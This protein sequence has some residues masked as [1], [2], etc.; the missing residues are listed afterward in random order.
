MQVSKELL[1][2]VLG[3]KDIKVGTGNRDLLS[4]WP[5]GKYY[6]TMNVY[7]FAHK[8]KKWAL[9]NGAM[10]WEIKE[11]SCEDDDIYTLTVQ[12]KDGTKGV[13]SPIRPED[14]NH[15]EI[16]ATEWVL[17]QKGQTM[18]IVTVWKRTF[19]DMENV[20]INA[21]RDE[22]LGNFMAG[23]NKTAFG[24]ASDFIDTLRTPKIYL[25]WNGEVYP[26]Y[27]ITKKIVT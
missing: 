18:E 23:E 19:D 12:L 5:E 25:G 24:K 9:V 4:Y 17:R 3:K 7:E 8:C 6:T 10:N 27:Y 20:E 16:E 14:L 21:L 1:E 26:K 13:F 15:W 22:E 11:I 2:A